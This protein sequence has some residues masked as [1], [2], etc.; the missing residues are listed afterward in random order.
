MA[1]KINYDD[2]VSLQTQEN[3]PDV[4]KVSSKD[5]NEIKT[6]VNAN[7]DELDVANKNIKNLQE[8]QGT[9]N[10][11]ITNLK[12]RAT[13]LENDNTTNK[14]DISN[15]KTD[16]EA[17]KSD[18]SNLQNNKVD[19]EEGKGL[20]TED[21]TTELK[22]KLEGLENYNDTEIKEDI[23]EVK[24]DL[25]NKVDKVEG[26]NLSTNDFTNEYKQKLEDLNNYDDT[27]IKTD[28]T[29]LQEKVT[30]LGEVNTTN[31]SNIEALQE[32]NT[33]NKANIEEL[34]ESQKE[35]NN[36]IDI[37][38]NA[39]PSETVEGETVN[40]KGTIP[41]K[42]KEFGVGGNNKQES[43]EGYN[44]FKTDTYLTK[45]FRAGIPTGDTSNAEINS[46]DENNVNFST[47]QAG[48][49]GVLTEPVL[50]ANGETKYI[51]L[52]L[53][54][55]NSDIR[56]GLI[57][58]TGENAYESLQI[59]SNLLNQKYEW[60]YT[61]NTGNDVDLCLGIWTNS[62]DTYTI[63]VSNI[64]ITDSMG[65]AYEPYG[66]MPSTE[67]PSPV[68]CVGSNKNILQINTDYFEFTERGIKN[69]PNAVGKTIS[70]I[71]L[72]KGQT[73]KIGFKLFSK[74]T[75]NTTFT[76]DLDNI[77]NSSLNIGRFNNYNLNQKY[78]I[79]YTATEDVVMKYTLNG[80]SNNEEFEFQLWAEYD[81]LTNYSKF[82]EG[83]TE[84]KKVNKNI[85]QINTDYFEYTERGIKRNS[86][87]YD[88]ATVTTF[89]IKKGQKIKIGLLLFTKP[90]T[91]TTFSFYEDG[92]TNS[93]YGFNNINN[94]TLN[95]IY[96]K[97]YTAT[98]DVELSFR[99]WGNSNNE[100][101]EFQLWAELNELTDY[102]QHK[103]QNYTL[104]IQQEMLSGDYFDLENGK[105]VHK[106]IKK[107][108]TS[109]DGWFIGSNP[110]QET[111]LRLVSNCSVPGLSADKINAY[112]NYFPAKTA[113]YL[114]NNE[115]IGVA[116]SQSEL[117]IRVEKSEFPDISSFNNFIDT[118]DVYIYYT[119]P[120]P[121][122]LDLTE[123]QSTILEQL[124][125]MKAYEGETN[126]FSTDETSPI[127][128]ITAVQKASAL[129]TQVNDLN[130]KIAQL[131]QQI[132]EIAGGN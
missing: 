59:K 51:S 58:K 127:F 44:E 25:N 45:T 26:K 85:L 108:I 75:Q 101:F 91:S 116:Q 73:I 19:K 4:N 94:N 77:E 49:F 71:E 106:F 42:F 86:T 27:Q 74:P 15:L 48:Y 39:L 129:L 118:H 40:I 120:E 41:V 33:Q 56:V 61:N 38:T 95:Q 93:I 12:N 66:A 109:A 46:Y 119:A 117:I 125:N 50:I 29:E 32:D 23:E 96:E 14:S 13:T 6:V 114:W 31:K 80:N 131:S 126:I 63:D 130:N 110:N 89:K 103:E 81:E 111:T 104:T 123:E 83:S 21:F 67:F 87:K 132:L 11:D 57:N 10:T 47:I 24:N 7:A 34:Q 112:S 1:S 35:Q 107:K 64:M 98:E 88:G 79:E 70:E 92:T 97:E 2:K 78:E 55:G 22:S 18:I 100:E 121:I 82:G 36:E 28:I 122:E 3:I 65:K 43:R 84:I 17:N 90:T 52:T 69:K 8:A 9:N 54:G 113:N 68:K 76:C 62:S 16:N 37:L 72:K 124:S 115:E 128:K 5:M 99:L 20:S 53:A 105:E 60:A 30:T 102:E